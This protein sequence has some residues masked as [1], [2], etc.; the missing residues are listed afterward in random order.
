MANLGGFAGQV[1]SKEVIGCSGVTVAPAPHGTVCES[2]GQSQRMSSGLRLES[3]PR[4][5]EVKS[6]VESR[7]VNKN[8]A[9]IQE[10]HTCKRPTRVIYKNIKIQNSKN[11][12]IYKVSQKY[13]IEIIQLIQNTK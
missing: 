4:P 8:S 10:T 12:K 2:S 5:P 7:V 11:H 13:K 6:N 1:A 3:L 9:A